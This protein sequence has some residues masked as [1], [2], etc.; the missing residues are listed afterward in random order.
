MSM[1]LHSVLLER[2][3]FAHAFFTRAGGVSQPPYDT[4]NFSTATG[5][6]P[7]A[8][9]TNWRRAAEHLGVDPSRIYVLKQVH[10]RS[11]RVVR[12][13]DAQPDLV[14][15]PGDITVSRSAGV[16]CGVRTADCPAILLA[17]RKSG[18]VAAIHSG[19]RGTVR[20]AA[21][22]GVEALRGIAGGAADIIAA[23]GPHIESCCFEVGDDVAAELAAASALGDAAIDDS[24]SKPHV[25]LRAILAEQLHAAGLDPDAIDH[26][27]GCTYCRPDLFHSYRRNGALG[28]RLL[29]AIVV[30]SPEH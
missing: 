16:A 4:L 25:K 2:E 11:H 26:V 20:N 27:R 24:R 18:A 5:D 14:N 28:G 15:T 23:V 7:E 10:G 13:Q 29:A 1:S 3:G 22:A 8:V 17:D 12:A 9:R 30:G 6:D 21:R 19:W